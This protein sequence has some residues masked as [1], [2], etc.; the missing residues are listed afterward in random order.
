MHFPDDKYYIYHIPLKKKNMC[1]RIQ[2]KTCGKPD[3]TGCG[4]HIEEALA[5]VPSK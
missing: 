4:F 3:W 5:G 1:Q 2:C